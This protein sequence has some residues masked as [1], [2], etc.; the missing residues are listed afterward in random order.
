MRITIRVDAD[1]TY[2]FEV[3]DRWSRSDVRAWIDALAADERES[4][5]LLTERGEGAPPNDDLAGI[6]HTIAQL[7][8]FC[9]A[10]YVEDVDGNAYTSPDQLTMPVIERL[11]SPAVSALMRLAT[12]AFN[13]RAELGEV[14]SGPSS[15]RHSR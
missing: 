3:K 9:S 2:W 12:I 1:T 10:L 15:A 4:S 6:R 8:T 5:A 14:Q 13:Q 7:K 11:D